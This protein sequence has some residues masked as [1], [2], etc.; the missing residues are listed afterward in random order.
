MSK[1]MCPVCGNKAGL[2]GFD[3]ANDQRICNNCF[4]AV[5]P[6]MQ[7]N[8]RGNPDTWTIEEIRFAL[9]AL[10]NTQEKFEDLIIVSTEF[11]TDKSLKTISV[12]S[13]S[14]FVFTGVI[15]EDDINRA[16][17]DMKLS[18]S[19]LNADA[20]IGFRYVPSNN[21]VYVWGTA[22]KYT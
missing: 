1:K 10:N 21:H 12:V 22:V 4:V 9:G 18:A 8:S 15:G 19:R 11:I 13:G 5:G 2:L 16:I 17:N 20:I 3:I 14:R 7:E 6:H